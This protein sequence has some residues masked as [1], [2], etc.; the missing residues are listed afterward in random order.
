MTVKISKVSCLRCGHEWVP[1]GKDI[2]ICPLCKSEK[3]DLP[4]IRRTNKVAKSFMMPTTAPQE[5]HPQ[6]RH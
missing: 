1:R 3:F 4:R 6:K 5:E 2:T